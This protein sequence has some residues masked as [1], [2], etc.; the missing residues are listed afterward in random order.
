MKLSLRGNPVLAADLTLALVALIWGAGI[1]LSAVLARGLTP[2]WAVAL[3]MLLASF[4]LI[5]MFRRTITSSS[6]RDW[7]ISF[8]LTAVL[9]A[10]F[11]SMTF[12][13]SYSTA[14]KQAFI[15]GLNVILVPLFVWLFYRKRPPARLFAGA[16]LT[17]AGLLVMGFTPGMEF[18]FGDFLSFIMAVS[19]ALQIIG[20]G[21]CARRVE[22]ARLTA[23]H[24]IMLSA[25]LT[26]LA[27]IFE[28]LPQISDFTPKIC[29]A[30]L[31][32]SLCNTILC[33]NMQFRAQKKTS[34]THA[35]VIFSLEGLFGYI[36]AVASG[37]DPFHLQG[38]LGGLMIIAGMLVT[39]LDGVTT[40]KK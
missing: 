28:P 24:I 6:A 22:P 3:R 36:L 13:L 1:P 10:V 2:L 30:L 4:F 21:F 31:C 25:V 19:Y 32:V 33:F 38:A 23:L 14:S 5:I 12:G 9:T 37:Q 16:G 17:T 35:A 34:A 27:L 15:G 29:G 11:V 20:G 18:N 39:E 8:L 40:R 7:K 26:A